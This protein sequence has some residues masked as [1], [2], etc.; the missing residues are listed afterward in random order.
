[1]GAA[2][3]AETVLVVVVK[4]RPAKP[5]SVKIGGGF[6]LDPVRWEQRASLIYSHRNLAGNLTRFDLRARAGYAELPSLFNPLEHGPVV[7]LDPSFRQK[8]LIEK[9]TV[10][11]L[12]PSFEL[13]IWEGYQFYSPTLRLGLSR[14]FSRF[15]EAEV[16]YNFRFVDFFNVSPTLSAQTSILGLDFRDPYVLSY[17]E[18]SV[19]VYLTD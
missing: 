3:A 4:V 13:G 9:H 11:T 7:K 16:T 14:F 5:A 18:P 6:G 19:R 2:D 1:A 15:V 17:I 10:A 12:A 8:G